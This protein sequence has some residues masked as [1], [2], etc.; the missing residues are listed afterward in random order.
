MFYL[1][2]AIVI[3]VL[4]V[5]AKAYAKKKGNI[6]VN[7]PFV[8]SFQN[9]NANDMAFEM[10]QQAHNTAVRL[11]EQ[12]VQDHMHTVESINFQNFMNDSFMHNHMM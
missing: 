3:D 9:G 2:L 6:K 8:N 5:T 1:F 11:H 10:H 4:F 12:A 7:N